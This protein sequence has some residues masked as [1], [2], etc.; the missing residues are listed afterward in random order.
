MSEYTVWLLDTA[1]G[2]YRRVKPV[3]LTFWLAVNGI[4]PLEELAVAANDPIIA[5]LAL[6]RR[7]LI[8]RDGAPIWGGT[9]QGEGWSVPPTAPSGDTYT[10]RGLDH[11]AYAKWRVIMA[12]AGQ[13]ADEQSDHAD[14]VAKIYVRRHLG[15]LAATARQYSDLTVAA[16][17]HQCASVHKAWRGEDM[18]TR[19]NALATEKQFY[20]RFV[21]T[22]SGCTFTTRY[23]LWGVDRTR[24]NGVNPECVW[25]LGQ[26]NVASMDYTG[27]ISEHYNHIYVAGQGEGAARV[28]EER[29]GAADVAAYERREVWKDARNYSDVTDL[30]AEGDAALRDMRPLRTLRAQPENGSFMVDWGLGD[31]VTIYARRQYREFSFDGL[32][33]SVKVSIDERGVETATPT[34]VEV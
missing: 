18:L 16:D 25:S 28:I 27:D 4:G 14:D 12:D 6:M 7:V 21:P 26:R 19:L 2:K 32:I 22:S 20:W 31:L 10:V 5:S 34:V 3:R 15:S 11:A 33:Q 13:D 23:P 1:Y 17:L 9:L 24:N 30:Q 8:L 29:S